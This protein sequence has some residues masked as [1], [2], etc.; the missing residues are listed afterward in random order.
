MADNLIRLKQINRNEFDAAISGTVNNLPITGLA[1]VYNEL[2]D[3]YANNDQFKLT[4]LTSLKTQFEKQVTTT[5]IRNDSV[6]NL[7]G[8]N[9]ADKAYTYTAKSYLM[10]SGITP[11][12]KNISL[13]SGL[14]SGYRLS[15]M[16]TH[17]TLR[18]NFVRMTELQ[19]PG[20][21]QWVKPNVR[22]LE[23]VVNIDVPSGYGPVIPLKFQ[24]PNTHLV[25][26]PILTLKFNFEADD[27]YRVVS[28]FN[29]SNPTEIN[30]MITGANYPFTQVERFIFHVGG[31]GGGTYGK[32]YGYIKI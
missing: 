9:G 4:H 1:N 17:S 16:R 20:Q 28:G 32:D 30:L 11:G 3:L 31:G 2:L 22:F 13:T 29:E 7:I 8:T 25:N 6:I 19:T 15:Q 18:N 27:A 10:K 5:G 14:Y 12:S 26:D 24:T 21:A 23:T